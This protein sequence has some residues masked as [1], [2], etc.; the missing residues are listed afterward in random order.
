LDSAA[1]H[2]PLLFTAEPENQYL[3][4]WAFGDN[5]QDWEEASPINYITGGIKIPPFLLLV[6]GDREVSKTVNQSFYELL[7]QYNYDVNLFY[8]PAEDHVSIDYD[9]GEENDLVFPIL[10]SWIKHISDEK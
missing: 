5:P 2:L 10:F 1:Y 3:L 9:L 7:Q 4:F 8:F 6:A